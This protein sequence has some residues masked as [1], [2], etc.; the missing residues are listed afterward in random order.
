MEKSNKIKFVN[1]LT[2]ELRG[3]YF[4]LINYEVVSKEMTAQ[5]RY[6]CYENGIKYRVVKNTLLYRA[7][8]SLNYGDIDLESIS[9]KVL[10]GPSAI[11]ILEKELKIPAQLIAEAK[12]SSGKEKKI[13]KVAYVYDGLLIGEEHLNSL[14]KIRSKEELIGEVLYRLRLPFDNLLS[15]LEQK[16]KNKE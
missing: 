11:F 1:E 9:S 13:L 3:K 7:L 10:K 4:F 15:I 16:A 5:I 2:E 14:T 8:K 12:K 6:S